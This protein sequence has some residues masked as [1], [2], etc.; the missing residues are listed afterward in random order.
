MVLNPQDKRLNPGMRIFNKDLKHSVTILPVLKFAH[1]GIAPKAEPK[2]ATMGDFLSALSNKEIW[3]GFGTA[4]G[5]IGLGW[6]TFVNTIGKFRTTSANDSAQVSMIDRLEKT[7]ERQERTIESQ[8]TLIQ[9]KD[10][11][12]QVMWREKAHL[13]SKLLIIEDTVARLEKQNAQF[14]EQNNLLVRR[15]EQLTN[16]VQSLRSA[17]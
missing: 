11:T 17:R 5:T 6:M 9:Q 15:V 16:E 10:E 7:V 2:R 4:A 13:E 3:L 14:L 8:R 1:T 12:N